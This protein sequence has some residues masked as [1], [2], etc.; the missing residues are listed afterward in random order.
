[1]KEKKSGQ[2][3]ISDLKNKLAEKQAD[4]KKK[5]RKVNF[6]EAKRYSPDPKVGL[7]AAEVA[8]RT[9]NGYVNAAVDKTSKTM[10]QII[11]SN[12]FTYFNMIFFILA[13]IYSSVAA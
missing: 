13:A 4:R 10:P 5:N 9:E 11:L 6:A 1:M 12:V 7:S 3:A 8:E 2:G